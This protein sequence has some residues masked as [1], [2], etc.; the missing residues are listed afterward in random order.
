[1][2]RS[3]SPNRHVVAAVP[4][5]LTSVRSGSLER[6][7]SN[8]LLTRRMFRR[9]SIHRVPSAQSNQPPKAIRVHSATPGLR[10]GE[11]PAAEAS[12]PSSRSRRKTDSGRHASAAPVPQAPPSQNFRE[13]IGLQCGA[14]VEIGPYTFDVQKKLGS[15]SY[16][17]VWLALNRGK[18][19]RTE[20]AKA[21]AFTSGP[22]QCMVA[23]KDVQCRNHTALR[24]ALFEV[25]LM[26]GLERKALLDENCVHTSVRL[27]KCLTY[28]VQS[29]SDGQAVRT[30]M[31]LLPGEQLDYWLNKACDLH[32][33]RTDGDLP[34]VCWT[35]HLQRG[36]SLAAV[37]LS[38]LGPTLQF[39]SSMAWHRD[40]NSH[41]IMVSNDSGANLSCE[42]QNTREASFMLCDLGLAVD[43]Q[44]WVIRRG[45]D[46]LGGA[47]RFTDIG[48]DC[49]YW[50]PSAWMLHCF[51]ATYL[52]E[53]PDYF[54]QYKCRLDIHGLGITAIEVL[55]STAL[56]SYLAGAS[57]GPNNSPWVQLL[58]AWKNYWDTVTHWWHLIL[59]VFS[60]SGDFAP[61]QAW[62]IENDAPEQTVHL[63]SGLHEALCA[64]IA[65]A[66][67][68]TGRTLRVL[69]ELTHASS[70]MTLQD[71]CSLL[72][73]AEL[74]WEVELLHKVPCIIAEE[75]ETGLEEEEKQM[76]AK[77][78]EMQV[79]DKNLT[80]LA[81]TGISALSEAEEC[82]KLEEALAESKRLQEKLDDKLK[83]TLDPVTFEALRPIRNRARAPTDPD[84]PG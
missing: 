44:G 34:Q 65:H 32:S 73:E 9:H 30:A 35:M 4:R 31:T 42:V 20:N 53:R 8:G 16:S 72:C 22:D 64:C 24:Q 25:Q 79:R 33:R 77:Q 43:S 67:P 66:G 10:L 6:S 52:E 61:V 47:W 3:A 80:E 17:T 36:C 21:G 56:A 51:G 38:Q 75:D 57:G 68:A 5:V 84:P 55:C 15:G 45:E 40:V 7:T 83:S 63:L 26:L 39:L 70:T 28:E 78:K 49:R 2:V 54:S 14:K 29:S 82:Q 58:Q 50:P 74:L 60:E 1:M 76:P 62:F 19:A 46:V 59:K 13:A 37:M 18:H 11:K 27:P 48:G 69:V 41:N 81:V 71:A 12:S 23:L